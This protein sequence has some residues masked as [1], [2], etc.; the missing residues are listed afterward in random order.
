MNGN[1]PCILSIAGSDSGGGAGIQADIKTITM[2]GG[3]AM[4]AI[5]AVTA[6][7][8]L[9]VDTV[10]LIPPDIVVAQMDAVIRDLGV[11][12]VKIGMIGSA[13]TAG[14]VAKYL[15][16]LDVPI[17]F[18]PVM[19]ATSG[20]ELADEE[21]IAAFG[22]MMDLAS[23]VTPNIPELAALGGADAVLSHDCHLLLKGGHGDGDEIVDQLFSSQGLV[24]EHRARRIDS[25]HTHG[26]GCTLAS[27]LACGLGAG[28]SMSDSFDRA[29]SFVREAI[30][31]APG[32]GAGHGP[33]GH[34]FVRNLS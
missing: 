19:I 29:I 27:A 15:K 20:S 34:P 28:F 5:T 13:E 11:D 14:L 33:L 7:N 1:C 4:T 12:A 17:I 22:K 8:T 30:V 16:K 10:H 31:K 23:V 25:I 24:C 9:G 18:D 6:Q 26:T 3:H 21:T 2:L 32:L